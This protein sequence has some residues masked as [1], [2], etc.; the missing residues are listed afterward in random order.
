MPPGPDWSQFAL[1]RQGASG[2]ASHLLQP[3]VCGGV[4][5]RPEYGVLDES[6]LVNFLRQQQI[7]VREERQP[8]QPGQPDLVFVFVKAAW[9]KSSVPLRVAILKKADNAGVSLYDALQQ[10][11]AGAWG[12]HRSNLAVLGPQ[13]ND[14]DD[15]AFVAKT[16]LACWGTFTF[17]S[18]GDL[19][20]LPGG[21]AEP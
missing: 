6:S 1:E 8:V 7:E 16:K 18:G 4:D 17:N 14:Q 11:S 21:Y 3:T 19:Y 2:P 13:G 9:T 5:L 15:L 20:V 12:V 10:G